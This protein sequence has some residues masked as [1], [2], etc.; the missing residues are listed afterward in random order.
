[1]GQTYKVRNILS[2][3]L[4][5]QFHVSLLGC[6]AWYLSQSCKCNSAVFIRRSTT[7]V[8][9][10]W[11][12]SKRDTRVEQ[13]QTACCWTVLTCIMIVSICFCIFVWI[14]FIKKEHLVSTISIFLLLHSALFFFPI[15][16]W[17]SNKCSFLL[18]FGFF[19]AHI[20]NVNTLLIITSIKSLKLVGLKEYLLLHSCISQSST[21]ISVIQNV[22]QLTTTNFL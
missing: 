14:S 7:V 3:F 21:L 8:V 11:G 12:N 5:L 22:A 16:Y 6:G 10:G 15:Y 20:N 4:L 19:F 18:V 13:G 2:I 9:A 17:I 1:M